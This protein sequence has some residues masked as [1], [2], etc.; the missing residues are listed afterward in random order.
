MEE[1]EPAQ[2][3]SVGSGGVRLTGGV[4]PGAQGTSFTPARPATDPG[5]GRPP[6]L[7]G[8]L[9][10]SRTRPARLR[11]SGD[12]EA[13][14]I[15]T[16]GVGDGVRP[17]DGR[18]PDGAAAGGVDEFQAA[19]GRQYRVALYEI[20]V[21][22]RGGGHRA[23]RGA[24]GLAEVGGVRAGRMTVGQDQGEVRQEAWIQPV[25]PGDAGEHLPC[26]GR[27]LVERLRHAVGGPAVLVPERL[28]EVGAGPEPLVRLRFGAG[29]RLPEAAQGLGQRAGVTVQLEE[30]EQGVAEA[31]E[32]VGAQR[33]PGRCRGQSRPD[34][35]HGGAQVT[36]VT[37][38]QPAQPQR[39]GQVRP[40]GRG[41]DG[42]LRAV[43]GQRLAEQ[44]D[45]SVQ[46]RQFPEPLV[47][48]P[49]HHPDAVH[50]GAAQIGVLR[51]GQQRVEEHQ[52]A[53]EIGEA[54]R[55]LVAG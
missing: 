50:G 42:D 45:G 18:K 34:G 32:T 10:R 24:G 48:G 53:F 6:A 8:T 40:V 14:G 39:A 9:A 19:H 43:R 30:A 28:G 7:P 3:M 2:H 17:A 20:G 44:G 25:A 23:P 35:V 41:G 16:R 1:G 37:G 29:H 55:A 47:A 4:H 13:R 11:D 12:G 49:E 46:V 15:G 5:A 36:C 26:Q 21:P 38:T 31:V 51:S 33:A 52:G 54:A 22:R 27:G